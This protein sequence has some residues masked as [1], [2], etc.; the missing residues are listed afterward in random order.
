MNLIVAI[1]TI[2]VF[3]LSCNQ[4][5]NEISD[6]DII[7]TN[8]LIGAWYISSEIIDNVVSKCNVC[9]EIEF[10]KNG[11]GKITIPSKEEYI[12]R[13]R[14]LLDNKIIITY[15]GDKVYF[16]ETEFLYKRYV[17]N[18]LEFIELNSIDGKIKYVLS[19]E[20]K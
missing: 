19:R 1:F 7:K 5:K 20:I 11:I 12:F 10:S 13:Y 17:K 18:K 8:N 6:R 14:K 15:E 2:S 3:S 16:K 9:P 4:D